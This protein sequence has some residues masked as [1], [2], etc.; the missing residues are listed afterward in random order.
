[1]YELSE[2]LGFI[3]VKNKT[4]PRKRHCE[5][6][7]FVEE[8]MKFGTPFKLKPDNCSTDLPFYEE[9]GQHASLA[10]KRTQLPARNSDCL[11]HLTNTNF[12]KNQSMLV[13]D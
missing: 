9:T 6:N 5:I 4:K 1:V 7:D 3:F 13:K 8:V 10:G 12:R 2:E 11:D